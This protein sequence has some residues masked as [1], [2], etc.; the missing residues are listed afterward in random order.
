MYKMYMELGVLW[1]QRGDRAE[2]WAG[3]DL[4]ANLSVMEFIL[5]QKSSLRSS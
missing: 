1:G 2:A 5:G 3:A 4:K